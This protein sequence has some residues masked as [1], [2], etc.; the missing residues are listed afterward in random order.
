MTSRWWHQG[1]DIKVMTARWGQ[2][3]EDINVSWGHQGEDIK[4]ICSTCLIASQPTACYL[5]KDRIIVDIKP[6]YPV[7]VKHYYWLTQRSFLPQPIMLLYAHNSGNIY[8]V[9]KWTDEF[10]TLMGSSAVEMIHAVVLGCIYH[11]YIYIHAWVNGNVI[12]GDIIFCSK[13]EFI[14][15]CFQTRDDIFK[16][17]CKIFVLYTK[18]RHFSFMW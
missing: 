3:G 5:D 1:E 18:L 14:C 12:R 17:C 7:H 9:T 16:M 8:A 11:T 15:P 13:V 10:S 6:A 2:Q 4:V